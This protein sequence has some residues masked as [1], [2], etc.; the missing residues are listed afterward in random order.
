MV[1]SRQKDA[2][3]TERNLKQI[4]R[5]DC[6]SQPSLLDFAVGGVVVAIATE[7]FEL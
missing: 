5:I 3:G 4:Q 2:R 7:L 6:L 1:V